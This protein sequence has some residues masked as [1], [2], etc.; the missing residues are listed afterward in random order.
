M[1]T[2]GTTGAPG[3]AE[4]EE[5]IRGD[6]FQADDPR[7]YNGDDEDDDDGDDGRTHADNDNDDGEGGQ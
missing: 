3:A 4:E 6:V 1:K 7:A 2:T 5:L